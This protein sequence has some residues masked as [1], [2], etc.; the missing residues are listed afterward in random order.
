MPPCR[1]EHVQGTCQLGV[2]PD[3]RRVPE[4]P[5]GVG[6][7]ALLRLCRAVSWRPGWGVGTAVATVG[8]MVGTSG[9]MTL[10]SVTDPRIWSA[11][12]WVVDLV[13]HLAY[14]AVSVAVL[15]RLDRD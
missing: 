13:P 5:A 6:I 3:Q 9:P 10:L 2:A 4:Q 15:D 1:V 7:G 14:G 8:A 12:C 11:S